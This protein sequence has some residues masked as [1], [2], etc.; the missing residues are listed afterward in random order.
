MATPTFLKP[1]EKWCCIW[2]STGKT[3]VISTIALERLYSSYALGDTW[4]LIPVDD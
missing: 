2:A 1:S 3:Q 4:Q